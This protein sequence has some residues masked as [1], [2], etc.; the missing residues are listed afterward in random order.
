MS[1]WA[2]FARNLDPNGHNKNK[3]T[4][5]RFTLL[6]PNVYGDKDIFSFSGDGHN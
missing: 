6:R 3:F 5:V 4:P 2:N 1:Y